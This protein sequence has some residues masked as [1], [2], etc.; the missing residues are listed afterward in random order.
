MIYS[1]NADLSGSE[2][3]GVPA[4]GRGLVEFVNVPSSSRLRRNGFAAENG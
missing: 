1:G 4:M 2:F 3:S